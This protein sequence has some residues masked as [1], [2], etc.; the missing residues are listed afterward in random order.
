[1]TDVDSPPST[2]F[3]IAWNSRRIMANNYFLFVGIASLYVGAIDL[4][5]TLSYKGMGVFPGNNANLPTQFWVA[6]RYLLSFS[7]LPRHF[8]SAD[9]FGAV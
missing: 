9:D 6:A 8:F 4:L 2:S 3:T 7:F 5:H 1:M